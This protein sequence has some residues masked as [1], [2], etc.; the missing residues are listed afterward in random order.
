M[1][2]FFLLHLGHCCDRSTNMHLNTQHCFLLDGKA[3]LPVSSTPRFFLPVQ[4]VDDNESKCCSCHPRKAH[5]YVLNRSH[6][7]HCRST[8]LDAQVSVDK[9]KRS[10]HGIERENNDEDVE[11]I[12]SCA[13]RSITNLPDDDCPNDKLSA[14]RLVT[15]KRR[16]NN[17]C[18][19]ETTGQRLIHH[20]ND[21]TESWS[22]AAIDGFVFQVQ[23]LAG[24]DQ[25]TQSSIHSRDT[26]LRPRV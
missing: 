26:G 5:S 17:G 1:L 16:N 23:R 6:N 25:Q 9:N 2:A 21:G 7:H 18:K 4:Y 12:C 8:L 15:A 10:A 14:R 3:M 20:A 13:Y 19:H 11:E 24:N 22:N